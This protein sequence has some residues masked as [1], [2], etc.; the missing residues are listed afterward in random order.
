MLLGVMGN[1][2]A[3]EKDARQKVKLPS[4]MRAHMLGNMRDH[5]Q[6]LSEI[7]AALAAKQR[8]ALRISPRR[9]SA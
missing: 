1:A 9:A 8:M 6:A 4:Q 2:G 3:A 5:L 7:Q